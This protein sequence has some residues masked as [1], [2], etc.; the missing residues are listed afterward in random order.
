MASA[1]VLTL[2][3]LVQMAHADKA[4]D[5]LALLFRE[6]DTVERRGQMGLRD[7]A[8]WQAVV[9]DV[10]RI[11]AERRSVVEPKLFCGRYA[12]AVFR[13]LLQRAARRAR[14]A[15][16]AGAQ[17]SLARRRAR[18]SRAGGPRCRCRNALCQREEA[19]GELPCTPC[20]LLASVL[21][22][23]RAGQ[24][25]HQPVQAL[26]FLLQALRLAR[27]SAQLTLRLR[28][29]FAV[30]AARIALSRAAAEGERGLAELEEAWG[31]VL[32]VEDRGLLAEAEELKGRL[33]VT[34]AGGDGE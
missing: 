29:L 31:E 13:I 3:T 22:Q 8:G 17:V 4:E 28:C 12:D 11:Q 20:S 21:N 5:A 33:V 14:Q 26:P 9:W 2:S 1:A 24:D 19:L 30:L 32:G 34:A 27:Q 6:V 7:F 18:P 10:V 15:R 16:Q 25:N 23:P